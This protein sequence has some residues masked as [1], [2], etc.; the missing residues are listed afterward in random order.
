MLI[1][2]YKNS[3]LSRAGMFWLLSCVRKV[4][5]YCWS[6]NNIYTNKLEKFRHEK[7]SKLSQKVR[8]EMSTQAWE[9]VVSRGVCILTLLLPTTVQLFFVLVER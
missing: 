3:T 4:L 2:N 7:Q 1:L 8:S 5:C 9:G 6:C